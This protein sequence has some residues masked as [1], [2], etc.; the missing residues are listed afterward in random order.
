MFKTLHDFYVREPWVGFCQLLKIER[1]KKCERCGAHIVDL[2]YLIGHHKVELTLENVNDPAIA[3]NR[4]LIEI[5]CLKCHNKD[6]RRFGYKKQVY[7]VWGSPYSGRHTAVNQMM[8]TGDIVLDIDALYNA[9]S[10]GRPNACR[11]NVFKLRDCLYDQIKTRYGQWC[12]AYIIGTY[13]DQYERERAAQDLGAELIYCESTKED[14]LQRA[15]AAND[16]NEFVLKWWNAF[17]RQQ[18]P[19]RVG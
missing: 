12:D 2:S 11:Y 7:I 5:I 10:V 13:A 6:H 17:G 1:G 9:I 15:A 3:L 18:Q 19:P 16:T 4:E 14:C 8:R